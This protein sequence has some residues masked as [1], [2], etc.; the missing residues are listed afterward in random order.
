MSEEIRLGQEF[1]NDR[2]THSETGW[3]VGYA[4]DPIVEFMSKYQNKN[5]KI[6]IPG[7][8]N[9]YEA[10]FLIK[11]KFKNIDLIDIAPK[12]VE[13]LAIKFKGIDAI[14]IFCQ[15]FFQHEDKYDLMIEQTFFCA[16]PPSLREAYVAKSASI[17][18]DGGQIIG[19]LFDREFEKQGPPFGGSKEE[20]FNLFEKFFE[21]KTMDRCYNSIPPRSGSEV[22]I[23][24]MKK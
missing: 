10:D 16:L 20:Y 14:N 13:S 17:L 19:V 18:K 5:D 11:N 12:A 21:I 22:F 23:Q 8:G 3:D 9:A 15:D 4:T 24:L 2:W 1:W 6:L 7:C